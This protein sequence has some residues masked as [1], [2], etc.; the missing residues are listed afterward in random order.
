MR[1]TDAEVEVT[2]PEIKEKVVAAIKE[3]NDAANNVYAFK[4]DSTFK[5]KIAVNKEW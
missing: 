3:M 2:K 5:A 1:K 4:L